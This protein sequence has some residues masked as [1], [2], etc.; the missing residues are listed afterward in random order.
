MTPGRLAQSFPLPQALAALV[1][2]VLLMGADDLQRLSV[3]PDKPAFA[4]VTSTPYA[5]IK[6]HLITLRSAVQIAG[7]NDVKVTLDAP[8]NPA[9]FDRL[10]EALPDWINSVSAGEDYFILHVKRDV[11]FETKKE[12]SGFSLRILPPNVSSPPG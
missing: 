6:F 10:P 1:L 11:R 2:G 8:I 7:S 3:P 4:V 9:L 5:E 12:E